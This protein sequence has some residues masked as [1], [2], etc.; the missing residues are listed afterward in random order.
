MKKEQ[1]IQ[2]GACE[3]NDKYHPVT[4]IKQNPGYRINL[5]TIFL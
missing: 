4:V 5:T 2:C 3:L 1:K